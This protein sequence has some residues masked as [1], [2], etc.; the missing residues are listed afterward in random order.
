M[1]HPPTPDRIEVV[2]DLIARF[3]ER[4]EYIITTSEFNKVK[5]RLIRLQGLHRRLDEK[6][7]PASAPEERGRPTLKRRPQ[8][9]DQPPAES[10]GEEKTKTESSENPPPSPEKPTLRRRNP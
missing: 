2:K 3:P 6:R 8:G 4:E 1:S 7:A 5:E 9:Q 10:S